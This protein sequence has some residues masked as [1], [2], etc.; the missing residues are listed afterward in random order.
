M[1]A[2]PAATTS[3]SRAPTGGVQEGLLDVPAGAGSVALVRPS[4]SNATIRVTLATRPW[5]RAQATSMPGRRGGRRWAAG[6]VRVE[7]RA[8]PTNRTMG[9]SSRSRSSRGEQSGGLVL[10]VVGVSER[11]RGRGGGRRRRRIPGAAAAPGVRRAAAGAARRPPRPRPP[12]GRSLPT[13]HPGESRVAALPP[14]TTPVASSPASSV[15]RSRGASIALVTTVIR[16]C[17]GAVDDDVEARGVERLGDVDPGAEEPGEVGR[18]A[19]DEGVE[20]RSGQGRQRGQLLGQVRP[21]VGVT[22][23][24]RPR[25][26]ATAGRR[27]RPPWPLGGASP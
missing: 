11:H 7:T 18:V 22:A 19:E 27:N 23:W 17:V 25:R 16:G 12:G 8:P 13:P 20:A 2:V 10:V 6:A 21:P 3:P 4:G 5:R 14:A 15:S 26:R 24:R 1:P 9:S